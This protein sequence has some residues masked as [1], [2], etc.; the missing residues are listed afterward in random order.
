MAW[1]TVDDFHYPT[2]WMRDV[3][4]E[5]RAHWYCQQLEQG[6]LL[7]F[8]DTPFELPQGHQEFLL[9]WHQGGSRYHKNVSYRPQKD[10]VRGFS[11]GA[12]GD[13]GRL[14][15][16]MREYSSHVTQFLACFLLPYAA[17]WSLDYASFR[18]F[19]EEGR[20]LPL[21]Q[22][23]DLLHVDAFPSRPTQGGRILRVF[24]NIHP[25]RARVWHITDRFDVLAEQLACDVGLDRFAAQ[26]SSVPERF[27]RRALRLLHAVGL[28]VVDRSAYD[29]FMLRFHDYLKENARFQQRCMKTRLE[30]P[31]RS[32]W[33]VFTDGVPHAALS[34][35]FAL[36][37][38][39]IV[40]LHG[41]R[42]PHNAPI[43]VLEALCGKP[44][45]M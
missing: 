19:E 14:R 25:S 2:G 9:S 11:A 4:G 18:P 27:L 13:L 29:K 1:I 5:E 22:R 3:N 23:N 39:Y 32:T 35:Q 21:H 15:A 16:I 6:A 43:R 7:F 34:G 44:L 8:G 17:H 38:T 40:P 26:E 45:A 10:R 36:E 33:I 31:P 41:L 37:Q 42:S 20:N 28:P 24:T 30:F 12:P